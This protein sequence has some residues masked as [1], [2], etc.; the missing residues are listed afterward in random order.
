MDLLDFITKGGYVML[1]IILLSVYVTAVILYKIYQFWHLDATNLSFI[2]QVSKL[3]KEKRYQDAVNLCKVQTNP[4]SNII[5][6]V[7]TSMCKNDISEDK[8]IRD[9]ENCGSR[10]LRIFESHLRSLEMV[11]NIAPLLGLLGTVI[12]MVKAFA[13]ISD[14]ASQVDPSL[15]AGGI[16]EALLTTIAGLIVAIPA[17]V[18]YYIID[19]KIEKI[20][21]D[22]KDAVEIVLEYQ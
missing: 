1:V 13:I 15:L 16:W 21:A 20:R 3:L 4:I 10:E 19:N 9:I 22:A 14:S 6:C 2:G 18:A 17:M 8:V 5:V 7:I 12:G 11:A